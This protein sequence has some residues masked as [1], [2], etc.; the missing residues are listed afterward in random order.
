MNG[1]SAQAT[2]DKPAGSDE[3]TITYNPPTDFPP[4]TRIPV[5]L[6]YRNDATPPL[7]STNDFSFTTRG[8]TVT[9]VAIDDKQVWRYDRTGRDLGTAWK[10][11]NYNDSSWPTGIALI[12]DEPDPTPEPIRTPID[13]NN[14]LG[15]YVATFYFRTH[16]NFTGALGGDL[17][18][19]H[20]IDDGAIF[21]LNGVEI[22]RFG[23]GSGATVAFNN[24]SAVSHEARYEGPFVL[25]GSALVTGDNVLAVE[26]HQSGTSSSDMVFGAE[27]LVATTGLKTTT[28]DSI[29]PAPNATNV[30][31]S[32]VIAITLGDGSQQVQTSTIQLSVNGQSV[33]PTINKPAGSR[34]TAISYDP[35]GDLPANSKVTVKLVYG[36]NATPPNVVT[37]EF[38]FTTRAGRIYTFQEGVDGYAA[39]QDTFIS[40]GNTAAD[41]ASNAEFQIDQSG[42]GGEY[43]LLR[44]ENIFGS[45]PG[46]I[47]PKS[48]I[49][50]ATLTVTINNQGNDPS[51]HRMLVTWDESSNWDS[52]VDGITAD[53]VEAA[54]TPD[55]T[56]PGA[57][58]RVVIPLPVSTLQ[59]WSDGT[60]PNYGWVFLPSGT[61][62][63]D[64]D[65]SE[66]SNPDNRPLLT[67]EIAGPAEAP[68][69]T[70]IS[71]SG[72]NIVLAWTGA[73]TLQSADAVT[74]P[75]TDVANAASPF[76][77][78]LSGAAKFFRFKP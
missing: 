45:A 35:P 46:Q 56:F 16:F 13:R 62:G 49:V 57:S 10:E 68:K 53:D 69:F 27:L 75:W 12:G 71:R 42:A 78:T 73:G 7:T 67:V 55:A 70:S 72:A 23:Y 37:N 5:R 4:H 11:K 8:T 9:L 58:P 64:M 39:T 6:I 60:K 47:P 76:N 3:T 33:T 48:K 19:R 32:A 14:D 20:I 24:T 65:S 36:D 44:F 38:S 15:E 66:H 59:A 17:F 2:L 61:D 50:S 25:P 31:L 74:G 26:V 51:L 40:S 54:T 41:Q 63:V 43:S 30:L 34:I 52:M 77:A 29:L 22:H 1:Q 21:Y 28:I 18:L